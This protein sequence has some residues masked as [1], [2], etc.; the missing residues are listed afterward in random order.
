MW[1]PS[2]LPT[3]FTANEQGNHIGL[4]LQYGIFFFGYFLFQGSFSQNDDTGCQDELY[5]ISID[6]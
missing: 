5:I 3:I 1:L 4:P 2:L 6:G